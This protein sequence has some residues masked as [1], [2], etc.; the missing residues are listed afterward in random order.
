MLILMA[1][2]H[3][4]PS[5]PLLHPQRILMSRALQA[6]GCVVGNVATL[7]NCHGS[8]SKEYNDKYMG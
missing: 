8:H 4:P 2:G 6:V 3:P 1:N 5:I 7:G